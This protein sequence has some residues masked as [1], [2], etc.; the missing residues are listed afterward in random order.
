LQL[1][2]QESDETTSSIDEQPPQKSYRDLKSTIIEAYKKSISYK[3]QSR[4]Q[5][6]NTLVVEFSSA[7]EGDEIRTRTVEEILYLT[8]FEVE[9]KVFINQFLRDQLKVYQFKEDLEEW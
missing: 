9:D 7:S 6:H 8:A 5:S 3:K 4:E 1:G 2:L